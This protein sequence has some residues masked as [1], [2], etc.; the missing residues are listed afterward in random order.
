MA[1]ITRR[2]CGMVGP[3]TVIDYSHDVT[4]ETAGGGSWH[5]SVG[6]NG[7][8]LSTYNLLII[9]VQNS[10]STFWSVP[11]VKTFNLIIKS[12]FLSF[13]V[14]SWKTINIMT[15]TPF[16]AKWGILATGG[17]AESKFFYCVTFL[18]IC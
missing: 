8:P 16:T 7:P 4:V 3:V 1:F 2:R 14:I 6:D 18:S 15:S 10:I 17:I 11:I 5:L 13:R 9:S 12:V